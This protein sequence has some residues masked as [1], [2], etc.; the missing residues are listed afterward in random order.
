MVVYLHRAKSFL[1]A[2]R[3]DPAWSPLRGV[4]GHN[5]ADEQPVLP[6]IGGAVEV[7]TPDLHA[8]SV[9]LY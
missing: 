6:E 1:E 2:I 3:N 4:C 5:D 9:L 8:A 7:R